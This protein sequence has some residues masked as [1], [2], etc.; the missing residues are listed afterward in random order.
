MTLLD[1]SL[2][3]E[4][5]LLT[6]ARTLA[7]GCPTEPGFPAALVRGAREQYRHL[8]AD[9]LGPNRPGWAARAA[10]LV[11][12][13][14]TADTLLMFCLLFLPVPCL[15]VALGGGC[16][17]YISSFQVAVGT[18]LTA[19]TLTGPHQC[20]SGPGLHLPPGVWV[21]LMGSFSPKR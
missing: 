18:T 8:D 21:A 3:V 13:A 5:C 6:A 16:C 2:Q 11:A 9:R 19:R 20:P 1:Y 12:L 10:T 4:L 7:L 15:C 14:Q 17:I